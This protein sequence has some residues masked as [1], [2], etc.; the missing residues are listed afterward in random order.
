MGFY[1]GVNHFVQISSK[2]KL[3]KRM[4]R[5]KT[6]KEE[7]IDTHFKLILG[8]HK[9]HELVEH[10]HSTHTQNDIS[11]ANSSLTNQRKLYAGINHLKLKDKGII[12]YKQMNYKTI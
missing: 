10:V 11:I 7:C 2:E 3:E 4:K 5:N 6:S 1:S 12:K 9:S 8:S